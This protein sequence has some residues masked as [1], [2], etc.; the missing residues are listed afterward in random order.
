ATV[1]VVGEIFYPGWEATV[2]GQPAPIRLTNFLLRGISLPPGE[3]RVEMRYRAT[4]ARNGAIISALTL[5]AL[6]ALLLYGRAQGA[7]ESRAAGRGVVL[8]R[9]DSRNE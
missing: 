9:E 4:A 1:L 6:C 7:G 8:E 2:D 3:H 5:V